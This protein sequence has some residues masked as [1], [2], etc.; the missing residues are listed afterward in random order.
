VYGHPFLTPSETETCARF[1]GWGWGTTSQKM[2]PILNELTQCFS[3][4][5]SQYLEFV[6][7]TL[8]PEVE[9]AIN[10]TPGRQ[11]TDTLRRFFAW[12]ETVCLLAARRGLAHKPTN[13]RVIYNF[14]LGTDGTHFDDVDVHRNPPFNM[15]SLEE[16]WDVY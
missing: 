3:M 12:D 9:Q 4:T 1:Q 14:G 13:P 16:V 7:R 2:L 10:V 5:E 6:A 15:I 8:T 11:P